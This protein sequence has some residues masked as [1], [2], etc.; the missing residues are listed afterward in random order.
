MGWNAEYALLIAFSTV[1]TFLSGLLI[2]WCNEKFRDIQSDQE[3]NERK[4][5]KY[6]KLI[7][8]ICFIVNIGILVFFQYFDF[9]LN[10]I[11]VLLSI[12]GISII[13][14]SFDVLLPVGISF[15]TFQALSYT[16][17]VYRGDI[18][19]EKTFLDMRYLSLSFHN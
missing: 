17:D 1:A 18:K 14:K 3:I 10:N 11:N 16:I 15:Y 5:R 8:A 6:K 13:H 12:V 2:D 7:V 19:A 4:R 9:L